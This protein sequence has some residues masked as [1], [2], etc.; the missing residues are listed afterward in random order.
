[1]S[2]FAFNCKDTNYIQKWIYTAC[3]LLVQQ[4]GYHIPMYSCQ[5]MSLCPPCKYR[6]R[7]K[8]LL[9][10]ENQ[11]QRIKKLFL[12]FFL[13]QSHPCQPSTHIAL[14]APLL[15]SKSVTIARQYLRYW[16]VIMPIVT[17]SIILTMVDLGTK[18]ENY[19]WNVLRRKKPPKQ[20]ACK[21]L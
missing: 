6:T 14:I 19:K 21:Q 8:N 18:Y 3:F 17:V 5:K 12:W 9:Q 2:C 7:G 11:F 1:M 4:T 13:H 16:V 20:V 10:N 15:Q